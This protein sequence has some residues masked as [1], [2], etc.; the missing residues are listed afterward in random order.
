[1]EVVGEGGT[2]CTYRYTVTSRMIPGLRRTAMRAI[3][4]FHDKSQDGVHSPQPF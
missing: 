3:L 1:M 2:V 4:M